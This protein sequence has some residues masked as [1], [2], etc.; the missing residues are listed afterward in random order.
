MSLGLTLEED[1]LIS[2][3][4][5]ATI[6]NLTKIRDDMVEQNSDE[7]S[8]LTVSTQLNTLI[9]V[10]KLLND[11][12]KKVCMQLADVVDKDYPVEVKK[13]FV[14]ETMKYSQI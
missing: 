3:V 1:L 11:R 14:D 9:E 12:N 5:D 6:S 8:I 13:H 10:K 4:I 7:I 2:P